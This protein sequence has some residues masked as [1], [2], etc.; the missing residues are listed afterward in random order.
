[1][2]KLVMMKAEELGLTVSD[3]ELNDEIEK[4]AIRRKMTVD[5]LKQAIKL[6]AHV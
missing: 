5:S 2:L 6:K 3:R 4:F 1:M